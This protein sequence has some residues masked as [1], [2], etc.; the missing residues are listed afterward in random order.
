MLE[1]AD[2]I[3]DWVKLISADPMNHV[4]MI[5]I[6][7]NAAKLIANLIIMGSGILGR[8][9]LQAYRKALDSYNSLVSIKN[10]ERNVLKLIVS[11]A[12]TVIIDQATSLA[13]FLQV[14][15]M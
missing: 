10:W 2:L 13:K 7:K 12:A 3:Q 5:N 6:I 1:S 9:V 11:W 15:E 14:L 4:L 8:A